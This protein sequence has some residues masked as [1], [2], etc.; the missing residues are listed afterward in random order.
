MDKKDIIKCVGTAYV[1]GGDNQYYIPL[2]DI[3]CFQ[4]YHE[5]WKNGTLIKIIIKKELVSSFDAVYIKDHYDYENKNESNGMFVR[6]YPCGGNYILR[7]KD[8][9]KMNKLLRKM[10][11]GKEMLRYRNNDQ[12]QEIKKEELYNL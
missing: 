7:Q 5:K 6:K 8:D 11:E 3:Y 9:P 10:F 1:Q 12:Y 2:D 4:L